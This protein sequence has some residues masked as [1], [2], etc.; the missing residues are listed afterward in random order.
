M[1]QL[2][3]IVVHCTGDPADAVRNRQYYYHLFF[4]LYGWKHWG[5]HA[6]VY[7]DGTWEILQPLPAPMASGTF[8]TN[9][10]MSN[11]VKGYNADSLHIAYVGG[12]HP[13][14][15]RP[16][17]TRTDEQR[18]TLRV[19]IATWKHRYNISE[20]IGH[21]QLPNIRKACPCFDARKE[22]ADV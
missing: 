13:F 11:G 17:D 5:Y 20:V 15:Y 22:Y 12:L 16:A 21:S 3:R 2:K 8:L 9:A 19:L 4:E 18:A 6:I 14:S 1:A 10:T 7:Q